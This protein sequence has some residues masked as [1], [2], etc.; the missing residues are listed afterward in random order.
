MGDLDGNPPVILALPGPQY[1]FD[2]SKGLSIG[3]NLIIVHQ[4]GGQVR[5]DPIY[6]I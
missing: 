5:E 4:E 3:N 6:Y 2:Y 1:S